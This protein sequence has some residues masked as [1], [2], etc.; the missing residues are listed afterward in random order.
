MTAIY[1]AFLNATGCS[2]I[3]CLRSLP[4]DAV[5]TA[6][7]DLFSLPS[8]GWLGPDIGYGTIIDGDLVSDLPD[9]LLL[10]GRYHKSVEKVLTANMALDGLGGTVRM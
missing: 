2:D 4:S 10:Q 9:R 1:N 6:N 3:A 8:S 5:A 7:R